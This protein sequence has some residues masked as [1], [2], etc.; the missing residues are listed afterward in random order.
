MKTHYF[1]TILLAFALF[2]SAQNPLFRYYQNDTLLP[3]DP[4]LKE[5]PTH[6]HT[7]DEVLDGKLLWTNPYNTQLKPDGSGF[8]QSRLGKT[9][10]AGVY[11]RIFTSPAEFKDIKARLESTNTGKQLLAVAGKELTD[12]RSGKGEIG[13]FYAGL[14]NNEAKPTVAEKVLKNMENLIA[15]QGLLAQI[16]KD[17]TLMAETGLVS[18]NLIRLLIQIIDSKP[19]NPIR[20][21]EAK[22]EIYSDAHLAKLFDFTAACQSESDRSAFISFFARETKGKYGDGMSLPHHW[23]RWNHIAMSLSYPLSVLAIENQPGYDQRI[24]DRGVELMQ[25]YLTYTY[26][27]EGMST[28]GMTYTFGPFGND[29]LFMAAI[30]RRGTINPFFNP[31]FRAIPDWLIYTLSP[32]PK[33]LWTSHGDT[34]SATLLPWEMMMY[35]KYFFPKDEKIDYVLANAMPKEIKKVPDVAAFVFAVDA[36]KSAAQYNGVPPVALPL[37]YFSAERGT[38]ITRDKWDRNGTCFQFDGR[39][40]MMFQSH[41][42]ADKGSFELA[43]HGRLWVVDGWRST[44]TKYHSAITIDDRGQGYFATPACWL[45]Y[46]D[47]P[48]ATFGVIDYKYSFDW[49][50]IKSPAADIMNGKRTE[51]MWEEG[52]YGETAKRL[53][54]YYPGVKPQR[55]PLR[56]VAEYF[57]GSIG[58]N[59]LIWHEDTWPMRLPNFQVEHAFRTAGMVKGTHNYMLI[60]DDLKKDNQE[61]LYNWNMPM[62]LDVEVVSIKQLVEVTQGTGHG[63]LGFNHFANK[64]IQGEYDIVLG[65]KRMK[66]NMKEVDDTANETYQAGRFTPRKGDPQLLVRV[67]ERTPAPRPNLEPNPRLEVIEKLKTEDMHQFYLRTMDIGKRLV[68]PSRSSDPNFKVLLFPYLHGE[69]I[70][71]TEWNENRTKLKVEWSDQKDEFTFT[72]HSDKRTRLK[73]MRDGKLIFEIDDK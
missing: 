59:P 17:Q 56:K 30:A 55:D 20:L 62:P 13:R 3:A 71:K 4:R 12:M 73:L 70:P 57:S 10:K 5:V 32:N 40:D 43:S 54:A 53:A 22:E 18:G 66:R 27:A 31:H 65:D 63:D 41:D 2:T 45:D 48:E 16:N 36:D 34:G 28:E 49:L 1:V 72:T 25:D 39:Q 14:K 8:A 29:I 11:P 67:L 37:T 15:I 21:L 23:R 6:K 26:T 38:F 7:A 51:T 64:G 50:W 47:K 9:P 19:Q 24:Y 52:I 44:E 42:H 69:E 46:V 35:M 61:R 33:A 68:I 58:N 60:V